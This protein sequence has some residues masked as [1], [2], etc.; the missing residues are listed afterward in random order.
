MFNNENYIQKNVDYITKSYL[1]NVMQLAIFHTGGNKIYAI[2]ISKIQTFLIKE[3]IEITKTPSANGLVNGVINLRGEYITIVN[4]DRWIGDNDID[5]DVYKIIIVCNYNERKIGILV[6]DIIKIEEKNSSDL[7]LPSGNDP[8]IS[9]VTEIETDD[10]VNKTCII[11]DAEKLLSD[12]N[13]AKEKGTTIYDIGTMAKLPPIHSDKYLLVAEDST[14]VIDKLNELF[15]S[16]G[17]KYEIFENGQLLIDRLETMLPSEIG[18][19][20]TDIE[21]PVKNGYQV[22]KYIK[23]NPVYKD[24]PV[25]SLTSMTNIGVNDKVLSLGAIA[26]INKADI[27]TLYKYI[28]QY[29]EQ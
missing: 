19:I 23:E 18:L 24:L 15:S 13:V 10:G 9:Y 14:T 16:I 8:K 26:L 25:L 29:L 2:N 17:I 5:E 28:K 1:R 27:K 21:M 3:S 12:I 6:K 20:V 11:F 4:L 7:K 22:I